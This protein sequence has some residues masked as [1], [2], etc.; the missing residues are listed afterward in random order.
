MLRASCGGCRSTGSVV[1]RSDLE[2]PIGRTGRTGGGA[3]REDVPLTD[4]NPCSNRDPAEPF[5]ARLSLPALPFLLRQVLRHVA[6][7]WRRLQ[8]LDRVE[9]FSMRRLMIASASLLVLCASDARALDFQIDFRTSTYQTQTGDTF[10]DLLAQHQD[11]G[12][13]LIQSTIA[14]GLE[15]VSTAV[16]GAGVTR[17]YS[18]LMQVSLDVG[19]TGRYAFQVGTDWGRGGGSALIDNASGSILS[20]SVLTGDLW[21]NYDWNDADVFTTS[22]D[23]SAGDSLTLMWV[24]FEDCCGG[25]STLRFSVDGGAFMPLTDPLL[26]PYAASPVPEPSPSLL[27]LLGLAGLTRGGRRSRGDE[28]GA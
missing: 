19:V 20:E 10:S 4:L 25:S 13:S 2:H 14:T 3:C 15:N 16:Y 17:D 22:F 28:R 7:P 11:P 5:G 8:H 24:G 6:P 23:F 27:M 1:S 21:W 9:H 12:E 18:T 26:S